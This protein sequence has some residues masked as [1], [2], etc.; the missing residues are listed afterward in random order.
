MARAT[1]LIVEDYPE[2]RRSLREVLE[3]NGF[4][5]VEAPDERQAFTK[6]EEQPVDLV[7]TDI[8]L[9]EGSGYAVVDFVRKTAA[10]RD[11]PILVMTGRCSPC[12]RACAEE[13]GANAVLIKPFPADDFVAT[14]TRLMGR[15]P[16]R[17][18]TPP[19]SMSV[20]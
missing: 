11:L 6:L 17:L 5:V 15:G 3:E 18:A 2:L 8:V 1:V 13:A 4:D 19:L 14:V 20:A 7:C 9:A 12:D 10:L 16:L